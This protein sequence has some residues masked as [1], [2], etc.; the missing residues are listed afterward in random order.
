MMH[1]TCDCCGTSIRHERY[2][3]RVE[4]S[5]AF[6]PDEICEE[7]LESDNLEQIAETLS[8]LEST[9]DFDLEDCSPKTF[10]FDLCASCWRRYLKDPLGRDALRRLNFSKN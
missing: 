3:A 2:V 6:D 5:P 10:R 1:F 4:V 8:S 7:D 9:D